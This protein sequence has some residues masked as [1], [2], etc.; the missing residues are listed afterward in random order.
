MSIN[1]VNRLV[2]LSISYIRDSLKFEIPMYNISNLKINYLNVDDKAKNNN[3][4]KWI[5]YITQSSS[6]CCRT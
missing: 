3:P 1:L 2:L 6:Y 4:Y 5:R